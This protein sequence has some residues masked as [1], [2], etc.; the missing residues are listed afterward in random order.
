MQDSSGHFRI[1]QSRFSIPAHCLKTYLSTKKLTAHSWKTTR[2][3][4]KKKTWLFHAPVWNPYCLTNDMTSQSMEDW[5]LFQKSSWKE[6]TTSKLN[7][8]K[9]SVHQFDLIHCRCIYESH[10]FL[11]RSCWWLSQAKFHLSLLLGQTLKISCV[12]MPILKG[13]DKLWKREPQCF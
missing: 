8:I 13:K 1:L 3:N 10:N 6:E 5:K 7:N 2:I 9:I 4:W 11:C 12:F